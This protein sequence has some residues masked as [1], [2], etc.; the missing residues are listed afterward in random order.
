MADRVSAPD[1]L[2]AAPASAGHA[3]PDAGADD[4]PP[5]SAPAL[6]PDLGML[7]PNAPVEIQFRRPGEPV[8]FAGARS[9][10]VPGIHDDVEIP[11]V[12]APVRGVVV[13]R[14]WRPEGVEILVTRG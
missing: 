14:I 13:G 5:T 3:S 1:T 12:E 8:A 2:D 11:D 9:F 10:Y 4:S 6:I 7:W